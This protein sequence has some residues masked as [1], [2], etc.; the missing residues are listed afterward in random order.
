MFLPLQLAA[1]K[2]LSLPREWF[3]QVNQL[4]RQRRVAAY[5]LLSSIGCHYSTEQA[6]MFLWAKIPA[7]YADGYALSDALLYQAAVFIT[8]GGHLRCSRRKIR[9]G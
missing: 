3:D 8:P 7:D 2:A 6:G 5:E 1:A 4:Y 9:A